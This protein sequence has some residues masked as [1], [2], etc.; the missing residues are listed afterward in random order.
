MK[1]RENLENFG[2]GEILTEKISAQ[3]KNIF[4]ESI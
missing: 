2:S 4:S 1:C 3:K